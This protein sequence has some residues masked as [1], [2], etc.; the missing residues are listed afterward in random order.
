MQY[1]LDP[2]VEMDC[3]SRPGLNRKDTTVDF[4]FSSPFLPWI[5]LERVIAYC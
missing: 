5:L 1:F 3:K 2:F 4:T